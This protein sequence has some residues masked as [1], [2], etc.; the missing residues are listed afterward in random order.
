MCWMNGLKRNS[1]K[2]RQVCRRKQKNID[3][4]GA[5]PQFIV[6]FYFFFAEFGKINI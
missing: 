6:G 2:S 5:K 4:F 1:S 3:K